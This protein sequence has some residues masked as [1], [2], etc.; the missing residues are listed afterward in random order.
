MIG[1]E[2]VLQKQKIDS[3]GSFPSYLPPPPPPPLNII[4]QLSCLRNL[5]EATKA[6]AV[7]HQ[8]DWPLFE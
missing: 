4:L 6:E 2:T 3:H 7:Y 1:L 8:N 5:N